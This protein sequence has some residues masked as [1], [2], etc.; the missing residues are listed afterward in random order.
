VS[1]KPASSVH[2]LG[3]CGTATATLA[4]MLAER[5]HRV[6]GSDEGVYPPMSDFLREK[7][8]ECRSPFAAANLDPAPDLVVVGNAIPR[9]NPEMEAVLDR[10]LRYRSMAEVIRDEFLEGRHPVVVTGTHGK[11]T[12]TVM[13]T[14]ALREC[15]LD[16]SCLVGGYSEDLGGSYR[17]GGGAPFVIEGDEYDTAYFDKTAKFLKYFPRTLVIN[18]LEFDHADIYGSLEEIQLQFRRLVRQVPRT[19]VILLGDESPA[20]AATCEGAPAPVETFGLAEGSTWRATDVSE[21][22]GGVEFT[23]VRRGEEL[24]RLSVP[25]SGAH[26]VRN[27]LAAAA[28]AVSLGGRAEDAARGLAS[29]H[30]IKRRLEVRGEARGVLVYDDFAHHPTAIA[31]TLRA[32]RA[33]HPGR[34]V[35]GLFEPR[36]WTCRRNVHQHELPGALAEADLVVMA[37]VFQPEKVPAGKLLDAP[38]VIR[39]VAGAGRRGWLLPDAPAIARHVG[40]LAEPG[41]VVVVMSNGSFDGVHELILRELEA[42]P[43]T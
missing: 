14:V 23:L 38:A 17:L 35:W 8:I 21:G 12:T 36:S 5:G 13:T 7:G 30:G 32:V 31:T 2:V 42:R 39:D 10:G 25:F 15:G 41:D 37:P 3:I 4:A 6:R 18:N 9:G 40:G 28:V 26:N 11:T 1:L 16:P 22:A 20:A 27:A 24:A 29:M 33:R 34:R 19:G 43:A